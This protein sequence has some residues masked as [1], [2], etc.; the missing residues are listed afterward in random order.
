MHGAVGGTTAKPRRVLRAALVMTVTTGLLAMASGPALAK[1]PASKKKQPT[2]TA[3]TAINQGSSYLALGDSVTF[4]YEEK[5]VVPTPNYM[6]ASS[7][8]GYPE[9]LG[10]ELHLNVVNPACPGETSAS[11]IDAMAPSNGCENGYRAAFPLHVRRVRRLLPGTAHQRRGDQVL[12]VGHPLTV[13]LWESDREA[14]AGGR[15][16]SQPVSPRRP[17][18]RPVRRARTHAQAARSAGAGRASARRSRQSAWP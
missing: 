13:R 16:G 5:Q 15:S 8:L 17:A 1:K 14:G 18:S 7:F 9:M 11:L 4:G 3:H 6:D 12:G 10:A 2:I